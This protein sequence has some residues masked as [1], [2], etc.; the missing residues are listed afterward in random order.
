MTSAARRPRNIDWHDW[1]WHYVNKTNS[2]WLWY[3]GKDKRGYG[4]FSFG[5]HGRKSHIVAYELII[6]KVPEGLELD[7][8]CKNHGC[9]NPEHLE[10]VTHKENLLRG[11]GWGAVNSRKTHCKNGHL[12]TED[13]IYKS[14][15]TKRQCKICTRDKGNYKYYSKF[16]IGDET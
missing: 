16:L 10:P 5:R 1:F 15:K 9:V 7:H 8:L 12:L 2:C 4:N 6:G 11:D 3:G 14:I 13:N